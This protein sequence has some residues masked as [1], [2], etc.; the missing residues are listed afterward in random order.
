MRKFVRCK[1]D[2]YVCLRA[3]RL[4][5]DSDLVVHPS[6]NHLFLCH[7]K[8]KNRLLEIYFKMHSYC[9]KWL[10]FWANK[11]IKAFEW[12]HFIWVKVCVM[13]SYVLQ[14]CVTCLFS[15]IAYYLTY[16]LRCCMHLY[17][18]QIIY[19]NQL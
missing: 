11:K 14:V 18:M 9:I 15:N 7:V 3:D 17:Q 6:F 19:Y 8:N 2:K 13:I 1:L 16:R 10:G 12:L 5:L 4:C